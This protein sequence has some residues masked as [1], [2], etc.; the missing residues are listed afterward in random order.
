[1]SKCGRC[2]GLP[3]G[4]PEVGIL[5]LS[6]SLAHT[7][8]I[9]RRLFW[10]SGLPFG[11][12]RDDVLAVQVTPGG[13]RRLCELFLGG[14][15]EVE[16]RGCKALLV[17]KGSTL[18]LGTLSRMQDLGSLVAAVR[19]EWL[20]D[21]IRED[22]MVVHFQP[23]I[24]ASDPDDIFAYECL[25]RGLDRE[26][27]L[28]GP[29]HM[30]EVARQTGLLFN[31]DRAARIKAIWEASELDLENISI[32]FDPASIYDPAY[33]LESTMGAIKRSG[34]A[35]EQVIVEVSESEAFK[36]NKHLRNVLNFYRA[37]GIRVALDDLGS[38]YTSL[39]LLDALRPDFAKL[40]MALVPHVDRDPYHAA[41][42]S[43]LL[44]L[45]KE[46]GVTVVAERVETEEQW[47]WLA[48]HG[49]DFA[50]GYFFAR[51]AFPP[52]TPRLRVSKSHGG[53]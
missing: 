6:P 20:V 35:P 33:C 50:Q 40:D 34:L 9:L 45:A 10:E 38:G 5:Y 8:G 41:V 43:R 51:P 53:G 49:V 22:R 4:W 39:M 1:M 16:L 26:G 42:A 13:L 31:L 52:P 11:D 37:A 29:K 3:A 30:F 48:A 46:L 12:P 36:D 17:E 25:L 19:G 15:S 2:E 28:V 24:R 7:R 44:E 27:A 14:L 21:M 47:R 32:N 18:G 23:V